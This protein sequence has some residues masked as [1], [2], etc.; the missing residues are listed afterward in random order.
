MCWNKIGIKK[1][2]QVI[3]KHKNKSF[4]FIVFY[5]YSY[6]LIQVDLTSFFLFL[7]HFSILLEFRIYYLQ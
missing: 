5:Q 3:L 7:R 2:M 1:G 4:F 6:E